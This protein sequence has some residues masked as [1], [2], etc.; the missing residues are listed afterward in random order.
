MIARSVLP[1]VCRAGLVTVLS[2]LA[3]SSSGETFRV[4]KTFQNLGCPSSDT[5]RD[6]GRRQCYGERSSD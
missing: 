4:L 2:M 5:V 1:G 6:Y 3:S